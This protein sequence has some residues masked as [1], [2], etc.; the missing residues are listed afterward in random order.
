MSLK[1]AIVIVMLLLVMSGCASI[2]PALVQIG[3]T[4]QLVSS[5][6]DL[7]DTAA[8]IW[9]Q[10]HPDDHGNAN[11]LKDALE[12]TKLALV[13]LERL[14]A[15]ASSYEQGNIAAA[16]LELLMAY[17]ALYEVAQSLGLIP[18]G[19][20]RIALRALPL[21]RQQQVDAI[22]PDELAELLK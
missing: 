19:T 10:S 5:Y 9:V 6:L 20:P 17:T 4:S 21:I 16:K 18:G 3:N 7:I 12:R 22:S 13:A 1:T 14:G 2:L 15:S 8:D 11:K